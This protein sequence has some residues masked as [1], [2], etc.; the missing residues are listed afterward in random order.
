MFQISKNISQMMINIVLL[1]F[2]L[3]I[4]TIREDLKNG[5]FNAHFSTKRKWRKADTKMQTFL[6]IKK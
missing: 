1:K 2:A 6:G 3:F 5:V 4:P